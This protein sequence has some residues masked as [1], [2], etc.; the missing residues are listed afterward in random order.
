MT[1]TLGEN[2]RKMRSR[3]GLTQEQLAEALEVS[4]Q[5]VS[6]WEN[7]ANWPDIALLPVIAAYFDVTVDE[8]LGVDM[9][10][11]EEEIREIQEQSK[12]SILLKFLTVRVP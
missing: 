12:N 1:I 5:A 9:A 7:D 2:I 4:P 10:R 6:R 3:R 11:R 8:L